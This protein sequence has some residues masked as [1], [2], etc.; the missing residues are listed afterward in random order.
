MSQV[1]TQQLSVGR[2]MYNLHPA[3]P[4]AVKSAEA[5]CLFDFGL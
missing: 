4:S 3:E 1:W 5:S 2:E